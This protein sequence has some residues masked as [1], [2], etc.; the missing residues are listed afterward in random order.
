M[1]WSLDLDPQRSRIAGRRDRSHA[2]AFRDYHRRVR[3]ARAL[4]WLAVLGA[5]LEPTE[6]RLVLTSDACARIGKEGVSIYIGA[7]KTIDDDMPPS[8]TSQ[9]CV[10]GRIGD[11]YLVPS[12]RKGK[13]GIRVVANLAANAPGP[14]Q[15]GF[16]GCIVARRILAF[17]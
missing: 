8:A 6:M 4:V 13:V 10:G 16:N 5:C 17:V 1:A 11:L 12:P 3:I 14:Q 2:P 7:A 15:N 9:T